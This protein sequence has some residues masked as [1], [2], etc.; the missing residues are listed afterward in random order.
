MPLLQQLPPLLLLLLLLRDA[1]CAPLEDRIS[2]LPGWQGELPSAHYSGY[3]EV[4]GA[5][6]KLHYYLQEADDAAE[7]K[8]LVLWYAVGLPCTLRA[9]HC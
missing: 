1:T 6:K 7:D 4:D 2:Q 3:V 5:K 8:P 9:R